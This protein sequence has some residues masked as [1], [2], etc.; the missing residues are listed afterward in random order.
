MDE[1]DA[2]RKVETPEDSRME[3]GGT[4]LGT[5]RERQA[6]AAVE[7]TSRPETTMLMEEVLRG[8]NL[9]TAYRRVAGQQGSTGNRRHEG[10]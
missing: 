1:E 2:D 9:V 4:S 10:R 8:E 3:R 5:G 6:S 7:E